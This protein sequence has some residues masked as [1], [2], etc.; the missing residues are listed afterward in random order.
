MVRVDRSGQRQERS[1][2][3]RLSIRLL[4]RICRRQFVVP[5]YPRVFLFWNQL[6]NQRL[7]Q[8]S[9]LR[10]DP[11]SQISLVAYRSIFE[12]IW[13]HLPRAGDTLIPQQRLSLPLPP[14]VFLALALATEQRALALHR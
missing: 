2:D 9:A 12:T 5:F 4:F 8:K 7:D 10:H 11:E 1:L 14:A 13:I 3:H 6:P